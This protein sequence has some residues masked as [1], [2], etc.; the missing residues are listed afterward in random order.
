MKTNMWIT[1]LMLF[2]SLRAQSA[3]LEGTDKYCLGCNLTLTN[4]YESGTFNETHVGKVNGSCAWC[5]NA[6]TGPERCELIRAN[7]SHCVTYNASAW[8]QSCAFGFAGDKGGCQE[9]ET[10]KNNCAINDFADPEKCSACF[11][12][13]FPDDKGLCLANNTNAC[14][15]QNCR[16]CDK[17]QQCLYCAAGFA[18]LDA[19]CVALE[20]APTVGNCTHLLNQTYCQRCGL[21]SFNNK[22]VCAP[23]TLT[24][25]PWSSVQLAKALAVTALLVL[26]S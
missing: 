17:T 1:S 26:V 8:C 21:G 4:G 6:F 18:S 11:N 14:T 5:V 19:G 20:S 7:I 23:T 22:G 13:T 2:Y 25:I 3:C 16:F 15:V 12:G 24:Q 9:Y 10:E